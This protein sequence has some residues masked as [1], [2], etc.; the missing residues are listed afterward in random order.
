MT[1]FDQTLY[2]QRNP[3]SG[4][5]GILNGD[6][7]PKIHFDQELEHLALFVAETWRAD[8]PHAQPD[9]EEDYMACVLYVTEEM[10]RAGAAVG[11]PAG[12]EILTGGGSAAGRV[13]CRR[14]LTDSSGSSSF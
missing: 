8:H 7:H 4:K 14:V 2:S 6:R 3:D 11:G 1:P 5:A 12:L 13:V 9:S 10:A